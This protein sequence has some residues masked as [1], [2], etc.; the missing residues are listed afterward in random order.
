M[1]DM[2][3]TID[4]INRNL[5]AYQKA[6][7]ENAEHIKSFGQ[8]SGELTEKVTK[9]QSDMEAAI[10]QLTEIKRAQ[11]FAAESK[12]QG[13]T[14]A[15]REQTQ[16]FEMMLRKNLEGARLSDA[17]QKALSTITNP[18]GGYLMP[19]A[20]RGRMIEKILARSP[21]RQYASV[22][23][24]SGDA[25]EGLYDDEDFGA[26]WV[27]ET[28]ARAETATAQLDKYRIEVNEMYAKP[29]TTQ[30]LLDDAEY[31]V[32]AWMIRKLG[33]VFARKESD[34]FI[35]GDGS[36]KPRGFLDY[37]LSTSANRARGVVR[38]V[39]SG[40][41]GAFVAAPNGFKAFVDVRQALHRDYHDGVVWAMNS[42]TLAEVMK[43]QDSDG[44]PVWLPDFSRG[45]S[46]TI[47][48]MPVDGGFDH[49]PDISAGSKSIAL[50]NFAGYQIVDR[51]AINILRDPYSS[52]PYVE[53]YTTRRVG[54]GL[55]DNDCMVVMT[56]EA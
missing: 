32:E 19:Q 51:K 33:L 9:M 14:E 39:K 44:R 34:A 41:S 43:M 28:Q 49:M 4:T 16:A 20:T 31:D 2:S 10:K 56:F 54:G 38:K 45:V 35:N 17:E 46:G 30:K 7:A 22:Q 53:F 6:A 13:M 23:T 8:Q 37:S 47:L 50:A 40:A 36:S 26:G 11:L 24:I 27:G 21:I 15:D 18:D 5:D 12:A 52:K 55:I 3:Q 29:K 48:G 42:A 1:T 25:L